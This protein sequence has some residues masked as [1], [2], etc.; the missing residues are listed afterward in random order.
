ML[1]LLLGPP[2]R[3]TAEAVRSRTEFTP[4]AVV[5]LDDDPGFDHSPG[6]LRNR[7]LDLAPVRFKKPGLMR[8]RTLHHGTAPG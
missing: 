7:V 1:R 8:E 5:E 6:R 4:A 3:Q 2:D